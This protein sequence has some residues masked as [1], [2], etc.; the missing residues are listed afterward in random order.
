MRKLSMLSKEYKG[1]STF[2]KNTSN[3]ILIVLF[4]AFFNIGGCG[5]SGG[6]SSS[7]DAETSGLNKLNVKI[8]DAFVNHLKLQISLNKSMLS[9]LYSC[10]YLHISLHHKHLMTPQR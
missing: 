10:S 8:I 9:S 6:V 1:L 3:F 7:D 5:G 4:I 2:F